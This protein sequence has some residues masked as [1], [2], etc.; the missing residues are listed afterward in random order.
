MATPSTLVRKGVLARWAARL[1]LTDKTPAL[2][3]GEGDTPLVAAPTLAADLGC[4][5]LWLKCEGM[6]P[7]GSF[8]DRGIRNHRGAGPRPRRAGLA[9]R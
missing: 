9:C 4:R 7:T 8:K 1:P 3:L 5:E 6:N 2:T